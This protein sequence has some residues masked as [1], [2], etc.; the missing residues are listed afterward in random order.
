MRGRRFQTEPK[1]FALVKIPS[2]E[3]QRREATTHERFQGFTGRLELVFTVESEYLFV[4]SGNYEFDPN[5]R[6]NRPDV[7]H[8]FNRRNGRICIPGTSIKGAIRSIVE[9]ISNS[10]VSLSRGHEVRLTQLDKS[11]RERCNSLETAC[12]ACRLFGFTGLRGRIGFEDTFPIEQVN[13]QIVKIPELW[14]HKPRKIRRLD[15]ARRFYESKRFEAPADRKPEQGYWFV[16]AIPKGVQFRS[17]LHFENLSQAELGLIFHALGWQT[18]QEGFDHAFT[19]K[20]G[21]AKPRC[22][23]A[24]RF[25]PKRLKLWR[26]SNWH[27]LLSPETIEGNALKQFIRDCLN[28]CQQDVTLFHHRSWQAL[29]NGMKPT[30]ETCPGGV[31]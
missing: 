17:T 5:A 25:E 14:H 29:V 28:E 3:P 24:V 10:C 7:W 11:H 6:G 26:G 27:A 12:P 1:P 20:L 9:A 19:P 2:E 31:Y 4:G 23:G 8:T 30:D 18:G 15:K 22:F 16:E 13:L 21:G